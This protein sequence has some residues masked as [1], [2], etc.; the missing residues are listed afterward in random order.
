VE[1]MAHF[2][3]FNHQSTGVNR[4]FSLTKRAG[5]MGVD[6]HFQKTHQNWLV[7]WSMAFMN[8]HILG[9]IIP[10]DFRIF[11]RGVAKN[12]QAEKLGIEAPKKIIN[13]LRQ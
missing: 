11:F 3:T 6:L 5:A 1:G 10:P 2:A 4:G 9:I 7:V 8:F 13:S 12:H